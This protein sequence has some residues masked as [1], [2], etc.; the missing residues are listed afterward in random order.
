MSSG[1]LTHVRETLISGYDPVRTLATTL[2]LFEYLTDVRQNK[3]SGE[4]EC[5]LCGVKHTPQRKNGLYPCL[6]QY[7][8]V[9]KNGREVN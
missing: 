8:G 3:R 6:S 5:C 2:P 9:V 1:I 4:V 7:G